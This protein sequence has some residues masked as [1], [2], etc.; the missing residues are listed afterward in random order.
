MKDIS[1][2]HLDNKIVEVCELFENCQ[3]A[4]VDDLSGAE[5]PI[6]MVA[7]AR[8]EEMAYM[9][10]HTFSVVKRYECYLQTGRPPISTRWIDSD[11]SHGQGAMK[12]RSRFVARDFKKHGERDR[13]DLFCATPPLE[14]LR[15]LISL[16]A[17]QPADQSKGARKMLFV[18]VKK[19]HL[20][21]LCHE[22]VYIDDECG[23]LLA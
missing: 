1:L 4:A 11:K 17:T 6:E 20:V 7:E 9:M 18:D 14:L 10:G 21:P 5:L 12:V 23:K 3:D 13:E 16:L 22:D 15:L 8:R 2:Q 19:A